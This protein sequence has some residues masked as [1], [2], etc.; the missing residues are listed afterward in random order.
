MGWVASK[1]VWFILPAFT[2]KFVDGESGKG[3]ESF[4]KIVRRDEVVEMSF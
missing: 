3:L 2:Y 1:S 4:G